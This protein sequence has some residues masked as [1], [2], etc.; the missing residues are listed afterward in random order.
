MAPAMNPGRLPDRP[1]QIDA[2]TIVAAVPKNIEA[3]GL[4]CRQEQHLSMLR[5]ETSQNHR[6]ISGPDVPRDLGEVVV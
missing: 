4:R 5:L 1:I 3:S 6:G 2:G